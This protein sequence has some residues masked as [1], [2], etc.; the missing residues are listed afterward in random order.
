MLPP[1]QAKVRKEC[2]AH[3]IA[4]EER[5]AS[6]LQPSA[7]VRCSKPPKACQF[8]LLAEPAGYAFVRRHRETSALVQ[9]LMFTRV[10]VQ[11]E[12]SP[13]NGQHEQCLRKQRAASFWHISFQNSKR[14]RQEA[15]IPRIASAMPL[16]RTRQELILCQMADNHKKPPHDS[17][18]R[19]VQVRRAEH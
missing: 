1:P 8:S 12:A 4:D 10:M 7:E 3:A 5:A 14:W 6:S 19:R 18:E 17:I 15:R 16:S 13:D 11:S 9:K 2:L